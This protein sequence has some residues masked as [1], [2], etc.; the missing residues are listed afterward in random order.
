[1]PVH[2]SSRSKQAKAAFERIEPVKAP[3]RALTLIGFATDGIQNVKLIPCPDLVS[4]LAPNA[5]SAIADLDPGIRDCPQARIACIADEFC[6]AH[7]SPA[8]KGNLLLHFLNFKQT[9]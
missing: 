7:R 6:F 1:M 5:R 2:R 3:A 8:R 4:R 9:T